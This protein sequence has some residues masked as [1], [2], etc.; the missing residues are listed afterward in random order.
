MAGNDWI[1]KQL[2]ISMADPLPPPDKD[3]RQ[4]PNPNNPPSSPWLPGKSPAPSKKGLANL[5]IRKGAKDKKGIKYP[6]P[7][8]ESESNEGIGPGKELFDFRGKYGSETIQ[9][10]VN[11]PRMDIMLPFSLPD[12]DSKYGEP[13]GTPEEIEEL[14]RRGWA[15]NPYKA[16]QIAGDPSFKIGGDKS[17]NRKNKAI[18]KNADVGTPNADKFMKKLN[19]GPSMFP[20]NLAQAGV[21]YPHSN[22]KWDSHMG[23]FV[24]DHGAGRPVNVRLKKG[25]TIK[26]IEKLKGV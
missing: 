4:R 14:K 17:G 23:Q 11:N 21:G 16:M 8:I 18:M 2:K 6:M 25:L 24:Q 5:K 1:K 20:I 10:N 9:A 22:L 7:V 3:T 15:S 26:D 12:D 13:E 19:L